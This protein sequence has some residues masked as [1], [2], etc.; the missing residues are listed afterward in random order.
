MRDEFHPLPVAA[1]RRETA[2]AVSFGLAVPEPLRE[3]FRYLP[4]QHLVVRAALDGN[5]VRRTYSISSG[6]E[7]RELWIT[8]KRVEGGLF[9]AHA[10]ERL[11]AGGAI[12]AMR[13][14]GR[15]TAPDDG[16]DGRTYLAI[17]AG[18]GIT[19]VMALIRHVLA[20]EPAS[21]FT[22]IYGNRSVDSIIFRE[23][24]DDLKDRHLGRLA[25]LHVLSRD[26]EADVPLLSG[27]IDADK[28]RRLLALVA[29]PGDIAGVYLCG[30]GDLIKN[31]RGALLQAGVARERIHFEY[32][33]VGPE[34]VQR[35]VPPPR[36]TEQAAAEGAEAVAIMDGARHTFRVPPGGLV[37]DAALAARVRVPYS[38]KGGMCC[39]CRAKLVEGEVTMVR[40]F[41]LEAWEI[42]AG[43]VLTCQ[44]QPTTR[45]VVLDYDQM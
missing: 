43:F 15:F 27:R 44:A 8:V 3:T 17:A 13:P 40:N 22:L 26:S 42:A 38:C 37:V 4:G 28:V 19:P 31:A 32:F 10:H 30:P 20:R 34:S 14:A 16:G 24:L 39:T 9:S 2:D 25:V 11:A 18:S 29:R 35:R 36:P 12:E 1:V 23:A 7:D 45:R 5:E 21:S 33:R 6:P 41:S